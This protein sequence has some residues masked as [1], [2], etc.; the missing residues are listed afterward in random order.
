MPLCG[1]AQLPVATNSLSDE[2]LDVTVNRLKTYGP[3]FE[4]AQFISME[5]DSAWARREVFFTLSRRYLDDTNATKVSGA[6]DIFYR[7]RGYQPM[8]WIG[9]PT[10][11]E[12]NTNFFAKL[13]GVMLGHF[14]HFKSLHN[15]DVYNSLSLYLGCSHSAE[16]RRQLREIA[17]STK[18]NEQTLI[19]LA[20]HRNP[21]DMDFLLPFM[22]ADSPAASSL[23]Y[24]FRN[25]YGPAAIPYLRRAISEAKSAA[26]RLEAAFELVHLRVPAGFQYL[27]DVALQNSKPD[28]KTA[29]QLERIRSFA[30]DYLSLPHDVVKPEVIAAFIAKKQWNY[31]KQNL[32]RLANKHN[33]NLNTLNNNPL[34]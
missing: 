24:H 5:G 19:C 16:A 26:I 31:P 27:Q 28:G 11:E 12:V 32:K 13:D 14:S 33:K 2:L 34:I 10:F 6:I 18:N 4:M 25:S 17:N 20:W 21:A 7:L 29:P 8:E 1:L 30:T 15:D 23:P 9:G 3:D 22:L